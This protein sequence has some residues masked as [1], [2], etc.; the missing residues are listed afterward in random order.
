MGGNMQFA[1]ILGYHQNNQTEG[2]IGVNTGDGASGWIGTVD[3]FRIWNGALNP[4]QM[5]VSYLNGS[6]NPSIDPGALQSVTM[7]LSDSNMVVGAQQHPSV[8]ATFATAGTI[9]I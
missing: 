7:A 3:E 5:K 8:S 2:W 1:N 9:D 4:L 6:N